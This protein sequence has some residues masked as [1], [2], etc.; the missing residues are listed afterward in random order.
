MARFDSDSQASS[1]SLRA[2]YSEAPHEIKFL[3]P[4]PLAAS[5]RQWAREFMQPDTNAVASLDH[6]YNVQSLYLDTPEFDV[7]HRRGSYGRGKYRIR[8]YLP[9]GI[10]FLERK[11]KT[12][13]TVRKRRTATEIPELEHLTKAARTDWR[14]YWYQRRLMARRLQPV[15]QISY[16]RQPFIT[17]IDGSPIRLT[18]DGKIY[19]TP[20]SQYIFNGN[21]DGVQLLS[22]HTILEL[23]FAGQAPA[24]FKRLIDEFG[25]AAEAVSKYRLAL[26]AL[27]IVHPPEPEPATPASIVVE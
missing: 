1:P 6:S 4:H 3:L 23:K 24:L 12:R 2:T 11:L 5:V 19:A 7:F 25:I 15:C 22:Q 20:A 14:G 8:Q 13:G 10:V 21:S 16:L 9:A 26:P 27:G 18:L 17:L